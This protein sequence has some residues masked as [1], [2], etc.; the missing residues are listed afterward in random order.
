MILVDALPLQTEHRY[1]GIGTY[2]AG[3]LDALT[4]SLDQPEKPPRAPLGVLVRAPH[5]DDASLTADLVTRPGV[6]T[7]MLHG[8]RR[9]Q[10]NR[11][12]AISALTVGLAIARTRPRV[13][14]ATE[15][16]GL[17]LWPGTATVATLYDLIPLRQPQAHFP[18]RRPDQR[19]GY[20]RYL[21]LLQRA[22]HLIAISEATKQDAVERLHIA[23]ERIS[24]TYL[25]VDAAH[26]YPRPDE[27]VESLIARYRL[28]RPYFLHVGASTYTKNTDALVRAF[29]L[30]AQ[31]N[32]S[33]HAL[34][35]AGKW[36]PDALADLQ[37]SYQDLMTHDLLR[38]LGFVPDADLPALYSGADALA[39][40]SLLEG[41]GLPV[42]EAM[43]CGTP[44]LTSNTSSLPEVGGDAALYADPHS[45]ESMAAGLQRLAD[46]PSLRA[47]LRKHGLRRAQLFSY[48]RAAAQTWDV[49]R[50]FL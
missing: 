45:I 29:V 39:Y 16:N 17:I 6:E 31:R 21:R 10:F 11:Q 36:N 48:E 20:A 3:L 4:R 18:I 38:V 50:Q 41:F 37:S 44:V 14:H 2:T 32:G 22:D 49:Y 43:R 7:V 25:A 34:Y 13:Y 33:A 27:E 35:I 47:D 28:R 15:P 19:R 8:P 5:P 24:V 46:S 26:F 30:F 9:P 12:W 42:L 23:P 40:P 1:R